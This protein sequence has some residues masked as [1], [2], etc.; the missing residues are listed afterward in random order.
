VRRHLPPTR[1]GQGLEID[2]GVPHQASNDS[3]NSVDFLVVSQPP[4][5]GDRERVL[6]GAGS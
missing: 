4:S 3:E 5:H 2:P 6:S 1:I